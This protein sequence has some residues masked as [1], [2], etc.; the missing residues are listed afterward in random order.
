MRYPT[1]AQL[2][3]S[4]S[5]VHVQSRVW[6]ED[7]NMKGGTNCTPGT[8]SAPRVIYEKSCIEDVPVF[9]PTMEDMA[10][11]F[12]TFIEKVED[13]IAAVGIAKI[14]PPPGWTPRAQG[15]ENLADII[16][17]NPIKQRVTGS[18]GVYQ[19]FNIE[20][21]SMSLSKFKEV[22]CAP[23][24]QPHKRNLDGSLETLERAYWKNVTHTPPLYGAD[25]MGTLFDKSVKVL[26]ATA[27]KPDIPFRQRSSG[28]HEGFESL[29]EENRERSADNNSCRASD[30]RFGLW[31]AI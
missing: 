29:L 14:V 17:P 13:R 28:H 30:Q 6:V 21:P 7:I 16:V 26:H 3:T 19:A 8:R 1:S 11:P 4:L 25:G 15:Y 18:R 5:S 10:L 23:E 12:E 20:M 27:R 31:N 2:D 9:Y 22:A 24:H